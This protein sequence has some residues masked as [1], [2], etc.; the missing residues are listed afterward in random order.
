MGGCFVF[1]IIILW[2]VPLV[3]FCISKGGLAVKG[4][5]RCNSSNN[6][7]FL[8]FNFNHFFCFSDVLFAML[9]FRFLIS[10][11]TKKGLITHTCSRCIGTS[12]GGLEFEIC[13]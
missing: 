10:S 6:N 11:C 1:I 5:S 8:L 7:S 2:V 13:R 9:I 12:N 4:S 3:G